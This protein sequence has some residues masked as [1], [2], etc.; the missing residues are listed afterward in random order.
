MARSGIFERNPLAAT[1]PAALGVR[2]L[3]RHFYPAV[4]VLKGRRP[5]LTKAY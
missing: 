3:L 5:P 4:F 2:F 1:F